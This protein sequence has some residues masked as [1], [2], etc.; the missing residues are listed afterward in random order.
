MAK[1]P[2]QLDELLQQVQDEDMSTLRALTE[3]SIY[4]WNK[5]ARMK[6]HEAVASPFATSYWPNAPA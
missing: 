6:R 1:T 4:F 2:E 3:S 5:G